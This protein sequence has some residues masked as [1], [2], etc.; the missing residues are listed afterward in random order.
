M[1]THQTTRRAILAGAS[2]VPVVAIVASGPVTTNG[3][4]PEGADAELLRLGREFEIAWSAT[5]PACDRF[6]ALHHKALAA[7]RETWKACP[8]RPD[9]P[10]SLIEASIKAAGEPYRQAQE[11]LDAADEKCA[12]IA[13]AIVALTPNTIA[14]AGVGARVAMNAAAH[15]WDE[16]LENLDWH[17]EQARLLIEA[18]CTAAGLPTAPP[19]MTAGTGKAVQS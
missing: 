18:L 16:P 14:G 4:T 6:E 1:T 10:E 5:L 9:R 12:S 3:L 11:A 2:A 13:R 17:D 8:D 15:W 19:N 7:A